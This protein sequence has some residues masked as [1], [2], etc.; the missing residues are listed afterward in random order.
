MRELEK[1]D[2]TE[3]AELIRPISIKCARFNGNV[4]LVDGVGWRGEGIE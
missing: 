2:L 3:R 1:C 4:L